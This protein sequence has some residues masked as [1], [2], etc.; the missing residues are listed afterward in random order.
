MRVVEFGH[1]SSVPYQKMYTKLFN[2]LTDAV[3]L[4]DENEVVKARW[5]LMEAQR[6]TEELYIEGNGEDS[7]GGK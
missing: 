6:K 7:G 3:G 5:V 4:L 1:D 2:A